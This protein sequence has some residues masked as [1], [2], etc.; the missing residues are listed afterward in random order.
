M[1][2]NPADRVDDISSGYGVP[3]APAHISDEAAEAMLASRLA[4]EQA[5][6]VLPGSGVPA[7]PLPEAAAPVAAVEPAP[8]EPKLEDPA[9]GF[10]VDPIVLDRPDAAGGGSG[11]SW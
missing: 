1:S 11:G 8:Q 5:S 9:S 3:D 2:E 6:G 7:A 4:A 10:G